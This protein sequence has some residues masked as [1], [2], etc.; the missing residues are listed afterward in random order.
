M[1]KR[2]ICEE[3]HQYVLSFYGP[4]GVYE[5]DPPA[6]LEEVKKATE[7]RRSKECLKT[8][9]WGDGDSID[10]EIVRDII[11]SLRGE[12]D[13]E[14]GSVKRLTENLNPRGNVMSI[15]ERLV[16]MVVEGDGDAAELTVKLLGRVKIVDM[17]EDEVELLSCLLR[18]GAV[19]ENAERVG[20]DFVEVGKEEYEQLK[21]DARLHKMQILKEKLTAIRKPNKSE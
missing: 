6:T 4:D 3:F 9:P 7:I 1:K 19:L 14:Y 5:F 12:T 8:Q 15:N 11:L 13:L 16:A 2:T 20:D 10:R 21:K 17:I 18:E